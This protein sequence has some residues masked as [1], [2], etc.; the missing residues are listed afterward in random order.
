MF[1]R[2]IFFPVFSIKCDSYWDFAS[3]SNEKKTQ[4]WHS[5]LSCWQLVGMV[6]FLSHLP[7]S[8][9]FNTRFRFSNDRVFKIRAV[10]Y[11]METPAHSEVLQ[12]HG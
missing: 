9:Q 8:P 1:Y 11:M 2:K 5:K 10:W 7:S 12:L 6:A 4:L 3:L